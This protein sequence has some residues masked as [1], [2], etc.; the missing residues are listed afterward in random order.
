MNCMAQQAFF[1]LSVNSSL[2]TETY[3]TGVTIQWF[4]RLD[5]LTLTHKYSSTDSSLSLGHSSLDFYTGHS[6]CC[7]SLPSWGDD[8]WL[9][10]QINSAGSSSNNN[11]LT[12]IPARLFC[13][14]CLFKL[15]LSPCSGSVLL[16][17]LPFLD[18]CLP[19]QDMGTGA[20]S[21]QMSHFSPFS[22]TSAAQIPDVKS[23]DSLSG[24]RRSREDITKEPH[25][26][27][28]LQGS[29]WSQSYMI[30]SLCMLQSKDNLQKK[31]ISSCLL[32]K[33]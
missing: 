16:L 15:P 5:L 23:W 20:H 24:T 13:C 21:L 26:S 25:S 3:P 28:T 14:C 29:Q 17:A 18:M 1:H 19:R 2:A 22:F 10:G 8:Q 11:V 30:P 4:Y 27:F 12:Q 32:I 31:R 9:P 7:C 6:M 33:C